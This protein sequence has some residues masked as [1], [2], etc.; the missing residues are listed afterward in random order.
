MH[1][2]SNASAVGSTANVQPPCTRPHAAPCGRLGVQPRV[3]PVP[4]QRTPHPLP[5]WAAGDWSAQP[6]DKPSDKEVTWFDET[7][8]SQPP[9]WSAQPDS[10]GRLWWVWW[11][12]G[13]LWGGGLRS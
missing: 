6:G 2:P 7:R 13:G 8:C 11:R 10:E 9:T 4:A 5:S 1:L 12:D 3:P